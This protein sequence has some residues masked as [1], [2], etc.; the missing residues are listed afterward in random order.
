VLTGVLPFKHRLSEA[1][2]LSFPDGAQ[3]RSRLSADTLTL[4]ASV[5]PRSDVARGSHGLWMNGD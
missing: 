4:S 3:P 1:A 2:S 5:P